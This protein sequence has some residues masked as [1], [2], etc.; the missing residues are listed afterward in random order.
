MRCCRIRCHCREEEAEEQKQNRKREKRNSSNTISRST[1]ENRKKS[2][3]KQPKKQKIVSIFIEITINKFIQCNGC[4]S[5]IYS[6][7]EDYFIIY[8]EQH[9]SFCT[10]CFA[11][12]VQ[13]KGCDHKPHCYCGKREKEFTLMKTQLIE[14]ALACNYYHFVIEE[15]DE[16]LDTIR[17]LSTNHPFPGYFSITTATRQKEHYAT[18]RYK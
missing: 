13:E 11:L 1:Y 18:V 6:M 2:R 15:E 9:H 10:A 3:Q 5:K 16:N 7:I 4:E 14:G 8:S 17:K 12:K